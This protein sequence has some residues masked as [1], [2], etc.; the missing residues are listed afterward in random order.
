MMKDYGFKRIFL[1]VMDSV[2]IGEAPDAASFGDKG[3][4]TLGHIAKYM[5]GLKLPK[6]QKI[7]IGNIHPNQGVNK[8]EHPVAHH[9]K[10]CEA[11]KGKDTMT[12]HWEIMG[13]RI[14]NPFQT[15]PDGFPKGLI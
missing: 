8:V 14:E 9:G 15:F 12:G 13:L 7:G 1:I 10:L 6:L 11:S 4:D 5:Q 2:G 3:T